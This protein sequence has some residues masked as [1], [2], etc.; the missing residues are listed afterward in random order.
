MN[1]QTTTADDR[2]ISNPTNLTPPPR[3]YE[4]LDGIRGLAALYVCA[5]HAYLE[6]AIGDKLH[7][8]VERYGKLLDGGHAAVDLFIVLSGFC[9]MLPSASTGRL[10]LGLLPYLSRRALRILPPYYASLLLTLALMAVVPT[11]RN[12]TG[13]RWDVLLPATSK[14]VLVSHAFLF[15]NFSPNW[16]S[17]ITGTAWSV[18]TEW[19]IYFVFPL[20]LMIWRRAGNLGASALAFV[21]GITAYCVLPEHVLYGSCPWYVG[22][23]ALGMAAAS[24]A[25]A[26]D[27]SDE[28][29]SSRSR[30]PR[31]AMT[32]AVLGAVGCCFIPY[33]DVSHVPVLRTIFRRPTAGFAWYYD[34]S[35]GLIAAALL[36]A[37]R[38]LHARP[39]TPWNP[40][41]WLETEMLVTLGFF[42]YSLYLVHYPIVSALHVLMH[43]RGLTPQHELALILG[44]GVPLA[45]ALSYLFYLA[46]ERRF[47]PAASVKRSA[48]HPPPA[49]PEPAA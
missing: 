39:R 6:V 1:S 25:P 7:P 32:W 41:T 16:C 49:S 5:H 43:G 8:G 35:I 38:S 28:P 24:I 2:R 14:G 31:I 11:L 40:V 3:R 45:L 17:K 27:A 37:L 33:L 30:L 20:L 36:V 23:F 15:H 9:L 21:A 12:P 34:A 26:P 18:A 47:S 44:A 42:S 22:L 4:Y 46:F 13:L 29:P 48:S 19:Q 10:R